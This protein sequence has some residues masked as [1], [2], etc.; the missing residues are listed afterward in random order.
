M[1]DQYDSMSR[2]RRLG[3]PLAAMTALQA[4]VAFAVFAVPVLAP[5]LGGGLT[6]AMLGAYGVIVFGLG[7]VTALFGGVLANRIGPIRLAQAVLG[8]LALAMLLLTIGL[9][10]GY[11]VAAVLLGLAFGPETPASSAVLAQA[12]RP[13]ERSL[14]FSL[15]QTGNQ[16]GAMAGSLALPALAV[17]DWRQGPWLVAALAV[18]L[19]VACE[20]MAHRFAATP[21]RP[22]RWREA[23]ALL[24]QNTGL[25]R[26]AAASLGYSAMQMSL[27]TFLISYLALEQSL[28]LVNAGILLAVAQGGGLLGRIGWGWLAPFLGGPPRVIAGLGLAMALCAMVIGGATPYLQGTGLVTLIFLFGLT[29][30]GWNGVF[31]AE[32]AQQAP[33]DQVAAATGAVLLASYSGLVVAPLLV[34]TLASSLGY[35]TAFITLGVLCLAGTWPLRRLVWP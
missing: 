13:P 19:A 16:I 8:L 33:A 14:V 25:G 5:R 34:G 30:S 9:A 12:A 29:A 1:S 32:V 6:P 23:L 3:L 22:M 35:G 15:R 10:I 7:A 27:N 18:A 17:G 20:P 11:L 31:L 28:D 26:L 2:W 4:S 24:R 21:A